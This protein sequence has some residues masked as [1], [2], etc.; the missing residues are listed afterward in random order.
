M[1]QTCAGCEHGVNGDSGRILE[2][3][4]MRNSLCNDGLFK[5]FS[6]TVPRAR[7]LK[8]ACHAVRREGGHAQ[9]RSPHCDP[10]PR[11]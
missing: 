3:M 4:T 8:H 6:G 5:T 10:I 2:D 11:A 7:P 1:V 9:T